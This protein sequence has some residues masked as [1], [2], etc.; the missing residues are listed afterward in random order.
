LFSER[1]CRDEKREREMERK[2]EK[3]FIPIIVDQ[4]ETQ[5]MMSR[6]T[7]TGRQ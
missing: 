3:L 2:K 7:C 5:A 1:E 6:K 4:S